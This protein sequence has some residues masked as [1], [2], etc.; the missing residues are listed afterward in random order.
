M[1][2]ENAEAW[3]FYCRNATGFVR[4]FGLMHGLLSEYLGPAVSQARKEIFM[5]K[6]SLIHHKIIEE[7]AR[8]QREQFESE[9]RAG[10][11]Y[12]AADPT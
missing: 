7:Q 11:T 12:Y 2:T 4:D 5:A 3:N 8:D 9:S 1:E 6:L 10:E